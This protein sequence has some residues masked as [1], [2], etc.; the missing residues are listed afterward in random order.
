MGEPRGRVRSFWMRKLS[1]PP[2][3]L[4]SQKIQT[5]AQIWQ[6]G[7]MISWF[8]Q[9][10]VVC[11][12]SLFVCLFCR[13]F[14]SGKGIQERAGYAFPKLGREMA[15][16]VITL[17]VVP[18]VMWVDQPPKGGGQ[19]WSWEEH[20]PW[21][22]ITRGDG[23]QDLETEETGWFKKKKGQFCPGP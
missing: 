15:W 5:E 17:D 3:K 4:K 6:R 23:E 1:L 9:R 19:E 21:R 12:L 14:Q 13:A 7:K 2:A 20:Q 22:A 18:K 10:W 16:G 8:W 11:L